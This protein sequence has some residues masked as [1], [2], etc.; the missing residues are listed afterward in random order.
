MAAAAA[1]TRSSPITCVRLPSAPAGHTYNP[2]VIPFLSRHSFAPLCLFFSVVDS[3]I[4]LCG[5]TRLLSASDDW[6][7]LRDKSL[8]FFSF[9]LSSFP[10]S[11]PRGMSHRPFN[12]LPVVRT[13]LW[14]FQVCAS[15]EKAKM[16]ISI[17]S[18]SSFAAERLRAFS[19]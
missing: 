5:T 11:L 18:Y 3:G 10:Q 9:S 4:L 16:E 2:I 6:F 14:I 12:W 15:A 8:Q 13:S 7:S 1:S 17:A 19:H